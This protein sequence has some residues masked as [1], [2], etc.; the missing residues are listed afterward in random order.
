MR[1]DV[2]PLRNLARSSRDPQS[3][4]VV[5]VLSGRVLGN[6]NAS[7]LLRV[8]VQGLGHRHGF[9]LGGRVSADLICGLLRPIIWI[10]FVMV[11]I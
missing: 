11:I 3:H 1:R 6:T 2:G 9:T 8:W 7:T 4:T 5:L 10:I